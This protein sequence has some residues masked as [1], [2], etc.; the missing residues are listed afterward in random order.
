VCAATCPTTGN[1][2]FG[3]NASDTLMSAWRN[4]TG[5][6]FCG[7]HRRGGGVMVVGGIVIMNI[8][9]ATVTE[10]TTRLEFASP[11]G[12]SGVTSYGNS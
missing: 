9:L 11:W 10:R 6:I 4:L 8:M 12:L 2:T 5:T 1:D 7:H 3:I